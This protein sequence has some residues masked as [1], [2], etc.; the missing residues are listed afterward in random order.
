MTADET[1][2]RSSLAIWLTVAAV[3]LPMAYV[4]SAGPFVWLCSRGYIFARSQ[5]WFEVLYAP[6]VLLRDNFELVDHALDWY[7]DLWR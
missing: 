5:G 7:L 2:P 6:L 3:L 1:K 4:L